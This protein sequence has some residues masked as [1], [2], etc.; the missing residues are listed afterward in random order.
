MSQIAP[1]LDALKKHNAE[2]IL[3]SRLESG[4]ICSR[5]ASA[6]TWDESHFKRRLWSTPPKESS[7]RKEFALF[8]RHRNPSA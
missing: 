1:L 8:R 4:S 7:G 5:A 2:E 3:P 6:E